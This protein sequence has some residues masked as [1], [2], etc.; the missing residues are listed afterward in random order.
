MMSGARSASAPKLGAEHP[1]NRRAP[2]IDPES[3][4]SRRER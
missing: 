3:G 1:F 4:N 2:D